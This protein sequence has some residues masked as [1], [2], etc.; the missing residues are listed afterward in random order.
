MELVADPPQ[1]LA[2][3]LLQVGARLGLGAPSPAGGE[4]RRPWRDGRASRADGGGGGGPPSPG[5]QQ[6]GVDAVR[7]AAEGLLQ[8]HAWREE[9]G[10]SVNSI[11]LFSSTSVVLFLL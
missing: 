1:L 7:E 6:A 5:G 3:L 4:R 9:K 11:G 2:Q 10:K 8:L